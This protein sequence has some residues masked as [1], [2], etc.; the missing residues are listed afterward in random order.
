MPRPSSSQQPPADSDEAV[1]RARIAEIADRALAELDFPAAS[2]HPALQSPDIEERA[3]RGVG[4]AEATPPRRADG[5]D[6]PRTLAAVLESAPGG[7]V[8]FDSTGEIADWNPA[9]EMLFGYKRSQ[10]VGRNL[11]DLIFP[12]RLRRPIRGV[13]ENRARS[14]GSPD[15]RRIEVTGLHLDGREIPVEMTLS[16]SEGSKSF[17][18]HFC[19]ASER[20]ERERQLAADASRRS[21]LL[22]LGQLALRKSTLDELMVRTL[23]VAA[24]QVGFDHCEI[25]ERSSDGALKL[26]VAHG[27]TGAIVG[28]VLRPNPASRIGWALA[29]GAS[30][31]VTG[32]GAGPGAASVIDADFGA[33]IAIPG[34]EAP[35]GVL[36]GSS[37]TVTKYSSAITAHLESL[38]QLLASAI[39][40]DRYERELSEAEVRVRTLIERLPSITYRAGLGASGSWQFISPQVE[41]I[42]GYTVE[43]CLSDRYWWEKRVHTDDLKRVLAEEERCARD[44]KVLDIEYRMLAR[45][46]R[47]I[48]VRDRASVGQLDES[49]EVV[50]EGLFTDVTEQK[51]AE[52]K[53][54]HLADHDDLTDLLNR[55]GFEAAL[56]QRMVQG[57]VRRGGA[58]AI[59]DLDHLKRINDSLGHAAGDR[60]LCDIANLLRTSMRSDDIFARLSGDEFGLL[61]EGV[62]EYT[63]RERISGMLEEL[64]L[65][66][67]GMTLTA[68]A[69]I[70]MLGA[71]SS[72]DPADLLVAADLA[73]YQAKEGGRDR[74]AVFTGQDQERLE[75]VGRVRE[76]IAEE[77]LRLFAQPIVP[78][79]GSEPESCEL[80]V[81]MVGE[82]GAI[83]PAGQFIPT[84]ERFGLIRNVDRWVLTRAIELASNGR[85][86]SVNVSAASLSDTALVE[87]AERELNAHG[88]PD[89]SMLT[90]E[91]T[92]T[93]ATP[94]IDTLRAFAEGVDRL[95]CK[96]SLDDVG[97]GFGSLTYLQNL[98]FSELKIDMQFVRGILESD[99]DARIVRS[100]VV[101]ARELGLKTVGEGV[102]SA[103][104]MEKLRELGVDSAQGYYIG[105]PAPIV[106]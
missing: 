55:R 19:D 33:A 97:T 57:G 50:V 56:R 8:I 73:L 17:A 3:S 59:I 51:A 29:S 23:E 92:E 85:R 32:G 91:I 74:L 7:I 1:A 31:V 48:W 82:D 63:A 98:N 94:S 90:F 34:P 20:G 71:D 52:D 11:I 69:G 53:L 21:S 22:E 44:G 87:L 86:V 16:F 15:Q 39:E 45:D 46:G 38:A 96:L 103:E 6:D 106:A 43:E 9:A 2:E 95:G 66:E 14:W 58:V 72:L 10:A 26:R 77:R 80:L 83:V 104:V 36:N 49:G 89:P 30:R 76:A 78:L 84:A 68:S 64:R 5:P 100:L 27:D 4:T 12:E 40:R 13:I 35:F 62:D 101:I 105:R 41:E 67:G 18:A 88:C 24:S 65:R 70:A 79:N 81:R 93:V 75:W 37:K 42:L 54:R 47:T 99:T 28:D 25:W 60:V 61:L 102:E